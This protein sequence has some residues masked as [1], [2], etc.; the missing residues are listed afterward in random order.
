MFPLVLLGACLFLWEW[1][2]IQHI[3]LGR[4]SQECP[5]YRRRAGGLLALLGALYGLDLRLR[6]RRGTSSDNVCLWCVGCRAGASDL[7]DVLT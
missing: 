5:R 7:Y 2:E 3:S 4:L 1:V 6:G